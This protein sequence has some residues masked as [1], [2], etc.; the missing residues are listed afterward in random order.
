M[1]EGFYLEVVAR[2]LAEGWLRSDDEVLVVAGGAA[3]R[4]VLATAGLESAVVTN[5]DEGMP[6]DVY[7]P[8][9]WS[10][11]NAENLTYG[12]RSFDV[13]IVHQGLHHCRSPHRALLEMY[14]VARRGLV[15]FEPQDTLLTR[16][17]VRLGFGQRYEWA[18][19]ADHDLHAGGVQNT[20]VP[21]FVYRWSAR[22]VAKTL[23]SYDP[24]APPRLRCFH[25]LRIP[26]A[27]AAATRSPVGRILAPIAVP[28]VRAVLTL[29]PGQA[30]AIAV[31]VDKPD[32][33]RD[34]HPWLVAGDA[35][36]Q[37][38]TAWFARIGRTAR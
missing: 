19:V 23:A 8:Y 34:L 18:A 28:A 3:D 4:D 7:A 5:L 13:C 12:D 26:G 16:L 35:G 11:Q 9:R 29:F 1:M 24:T 37:V 30:N 21:N 32:T 20:N 25:D 10:R 38:N 14:R 36:P 17:G 15:L 2:L 22:E 6:S 33:H 31:V 27:A